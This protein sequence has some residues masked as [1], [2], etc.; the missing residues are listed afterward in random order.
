MMNNE[1]F[2]IIFVVE[3]TAKCKSDD[4]YINEILHYC[5][6]VGENKISYVYL[7]GKFKYNED[8]IIKEI[9][10]LQ[11]TY[12]TLTG[13]VSHVIHVF[14]KDRAHVKWEDASFV[15][16]VT[17]YCHDNNYG[18]VWFVKTIEEVMLGKP[19]KKGEKGPKAIN[20]IKRKNI[21]NIDRSNLLAA[22]NVNKEGKSNIITV[23][24]KLLTPLK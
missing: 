19:V 3:T 22:Q 10:N 9:H 2:Q 21:K 24:N 6:K 7:E 20:F 17:K 4:M 5:Y 1:P 12:N 18:L 8:R 13:G 16:N 23:L 14:D 11:N 15:N